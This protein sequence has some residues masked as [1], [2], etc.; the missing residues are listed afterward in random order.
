MNRLALAHQGDNAAFNNVYELGNAIWRSQCATAQSSD[1]QSS[2]AQSS[3]LMA[4]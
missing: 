3:E 1:A 2:E 4:L